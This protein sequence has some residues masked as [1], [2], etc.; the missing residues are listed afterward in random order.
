MPQSPR[1]LVIVRAGD[2]SLHPGWTSSVAT[3]TWDLVVSYY[4]DDPVRFRDAGERRIDD[5]GPKW[6]GLYTLLTRGDFWRAYDYIWFP[7]D[8]LK[9]EQHAVD[10]LFALTAELG[11]ELSQPA[12]SWTSHYSHFITLRHPSFVARFTD[13]I[14][15]MAPCFRREFLEA[16]LPTLGETQSGWGFDWA[17]PRLQTRGIRGCAILDDVE[18][19]H[20]RPIGGPIYA[21]LRALG[22]SA[23]DECNATLRKYSIKVR[24]PMRITMAIDR[25][26]RLLD[27]TV[28]ED[29]ERLD[30]LL[31]RDASALFSSRNAFDL[32]HVVVTMQ[33]PERPG[34]WGR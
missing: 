34:R 26:G 3:R 20:T 18:M 12:L 29:G 9:I 19:T 13:F 25:A 2:Q 5:K 7:D 33:D 28:S 31:T 16:C 32:Q 6:P 24:F 11:L 21:T 17:W 27:A 30:A 22:V 10:R 15:I 8:D 23:D 1:H 14:E 4:G